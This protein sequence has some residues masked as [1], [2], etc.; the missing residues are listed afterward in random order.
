MQ[1]IRAAYR[2]D[3][4]GVGELMRRNERFV[5]FRPI[6]DNAFPRSGLGMALLPET[7]AATDKSVLPGG[8]VLLVSTLVPDARGRPRPFD[9]IMLDQDMGAA[10]QGAA[11]ADLYLGVGPVALI[12]LIYWVLTGF[13]KH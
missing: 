3:P 11:R 7:G 8:D 9:R 2:A 5:F 4:H 10:I 1:S 13:R 12:W 6:A